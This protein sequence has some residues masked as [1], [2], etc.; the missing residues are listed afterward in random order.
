MTLE[1][2]RCAVC[3]NLAT[4][5]LNGVPVCDECTSLS[6]AML[7]SHRLT[8]SLQAKRASRRN[9]RRPAWVKS[10]KPKREEE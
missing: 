6:G 8:K 7:R 4:T 1:P 5:S 9:G 2:V 3:P 10:R